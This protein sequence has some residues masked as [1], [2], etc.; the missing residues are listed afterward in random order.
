MLIQERNLTDV[1]VIVE[2]TKRSV[3]Y[4]AMP[5]GGGAVGIVELVQTEVL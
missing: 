4:I 2:S 1:N 5:M 3:I